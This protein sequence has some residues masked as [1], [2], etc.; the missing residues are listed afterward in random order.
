MASEEETIRQLL[1]DL[2]VLEGSARVTQSQLE[3]V[4]ASVN[5]IIIANSTL[6]GLKKQTGDIQALIPI[7]AGS[8]IP[9]DVKK[10]DK[11]I[12]GVGAGVCIERSLEEALTELKTRQAELEKLRTAL[13]QQLIQTVSKTEEV[14]GKLSELVK[15]KGGESIAVV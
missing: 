4:T 7:G 9:S 10:V 2:R 14:R 1:V 11:T 8:Y 6:D 13:Q 3:I 15:K 12:M 5:E